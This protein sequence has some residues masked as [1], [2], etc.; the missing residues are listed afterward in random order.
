MTRSISAQDLSRAL[1]AD[2]PPVD[3]ELFAATLAHVARTAAAQRPERGVSRGVKVG[4]VAAS[5][6]ITAFGAAHASD[7]FLEP[8][9]SDITPPSDPGR[10]SPADQAPDTGTSPRQSEG[11]DEDGRADRDS[12]PLKTGPT[13]STDDEVG[14]QTQSDA[15]TPPATEPEESDGAADDDG[16]EDDD[17]ND[18]G[19]GGNDGAEGDDPNDDGAGGDDGAEGDDPNDEGAGGDD[20]A[21][22]ADTNDDGGGAG[23]NDDGPTNDGP[24]DEGVSHDRV[25]DEGGVDVVEDGPEGADGA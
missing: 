13:S 3:D 8:S 17:P 4:V 7:R 23:L 24:H 16:A 19:A 1:R 25:E 10:G 9:E 22:G 15:P 18:D 2:V 20:G 21:D 11:G 14:D 5:T 12:Q 6:L